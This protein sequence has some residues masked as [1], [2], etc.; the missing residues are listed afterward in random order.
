M[1]T[2]NQMNY[3]HALLCGTV[4]SLLT[5]SCAYAVES[6]VTP[7]PSVGHRP[8]INGL[9]LATSSGDITQS[10]TLLTVGATISRT[11]GTV[12]DVDGDPVETGEYC[13]WYR[14]DPNTL[15][16]TLVKD[17]GAT[18]RNCEYTLQVADLGFKIKSVLKFFSDGII[19]AG[20]GFK[21]NPSESWPV[22]VL[23]ANDV[24]PAPIPF[25]ASTTLNTH[26]APYTF[27]LN[28]GFP[29]TGFVGATFTI[30]IGGSTSNNSQYNW[31]SS[32]PSWINVDTRGIVTF[33]SKP[34]S[35]TNKVRVFASSK[36]DKSILYYKDIILNDWFT[37]NSTNKGNWA[38]TDN[39][40]R[41]LGNGYEMP[42]RARLGMAVVGNSFARRGGLG[43]WSEWGAMHSYSNGWVA[44]NQFYW[45]AEQMTGSSR[46]IV[47][48]SDGYVFWENT[49][50]SFVYHRV[51]VVSL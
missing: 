43:L 41:S 26:V 29:S 21:V 49:N 3:P 19:A 4:I 46:Y 50:G 30:Q 6:P 15:A 9:V 2:K 32:Q 42:T 48:F 10:S 1:N 16:E 25:P 36:N 11:L 51:C 40:C 33:R 23:S 5:A 18:D 12:A 34:S 35:S 17:P 7:G 37:N 22:E 14:V 13:M 39:Y 20:N 24:G 28:S 31:S 45:T 44:G 27:T 8:V 38:S 47:R